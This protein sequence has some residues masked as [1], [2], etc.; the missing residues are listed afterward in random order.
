MLINLTNHASVNW[1]KKEKNLALH[2]YGSI[3][4]MHFPTINPHASA[5]EVYEIALQYAKKIQ[6]LSPTGVLIMGE[7]TFCFSLVA[8]LQ[9]RGISCIAATCH[10]NTIDHSDGAKTTIFRFEQFRTYPPLSQLFMAISFSLPNHP[11]LH[12]H[13]T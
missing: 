7:F 4:D 3:Y 12:K 11:L 6:D 2:L 13:E 5:N 8:L 9:Q 10:R 1:C